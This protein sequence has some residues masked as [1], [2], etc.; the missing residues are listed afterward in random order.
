MNNVTTT[1]GVRMLMN[2]SHKSNKKRKVDSILE[3]TI[4]HHDKVSN[5][6]MDADVDDNVD[7]DDDNDEWGHV[8]PESVLKLSFE[9]GSVSKAAMAIQEES[10]HKYALIALHI[11]LS[12]LKERDTP[13]PDN[14]SSLLSTQHPQQQQQH[15]RH[16]NST[17]NH[18][19][20]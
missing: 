16:I 8:H 15:Y 2:T 4:D 3:D 17:I 20:K 10:I 12:M 5:N 1:A 11:R 9:E 6:D 14:I 13:L 7:D 18:F 19:H